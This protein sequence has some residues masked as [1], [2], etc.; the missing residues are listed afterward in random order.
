MVCHDLEKGKP[1]NYILYSNPKA[2]VD[3]YLITFAGFY[4]LSI[5]PAKFNTGLKHGM[6]KCE[7]K[8]LGHFLFWVKYCK[9]IWTSS[10]LKPIVWLSRR[11][12]GSN[13]NPKHKTWL[14]YINKISFLRGGWSNQSSSYFSYFPSTDLAR[15]HAKSH[16]QHGYFQGYVPKHQPSDTPSGSRGFF[17]HPAFA[18]LENLLT[19]F[20]RQILVG[21]NTATG[22]KCGYINNDMLM[23]DLIV[24]YHLHI[25]HGWTWWFSICWVTGG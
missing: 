20:A 8:Q 16:S 12:F 23:D 17:G 21:G 10:C 15:C 4:L 14:I 19:V 3:K 11:L 18:S 6:G 5:S 2:N 1:I 24:I 22:K 9:F 7:E 13:V 25:E